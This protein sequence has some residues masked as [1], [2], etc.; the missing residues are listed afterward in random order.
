MTT[1]NTTRQN[2]GGRPTQAEAARLEERIRQAA[3]AAFVEHGYEGVA[4]ED[5]AR[6]AEVSKPTLY[7]RFPDKRV[8]FATVIPWAFQNLHWVEPVD[9][10]HDDDLVVALTAIARSIQRHA[11]APD[12]VRLIRTAIAE[13]ARFP[14]LA[15]S[16]KGMAWSPGIQAVVEVLRRHV[17]KGTITVDEPEIAAE[18][19]IAMVAA[20]PALFA[21]FGSRR[22]RKSEEFRLQHAVALFLNGVLTH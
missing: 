9:E 12:I 10:T 17:V 5:V 18:Q 13:S 8:L 16:A 20:M 15:L 11:L 7:A 4:M 3:I 19:F 21:A 14:E 1:R 6:A 2:R 22:S